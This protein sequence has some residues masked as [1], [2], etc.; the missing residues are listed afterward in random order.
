MP[1]ARFEVLVLPYATEA[2]ADIAFAVFRDRVLG[3][4]CWHAVRGGGDRGEL[5]LDAARRHA[6]A[7][8]GI[9]R[10]HAHVALDSRATVVIEAIAG[11]YE[12]ALH[13]FGVCV[14][15][16]GLCVC[17]GRELRWLS[18]RAA[19]GLL[20]SE[21]E[22]DALWELRHRIGRHPACR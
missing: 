22:R 7:Q 21:P 15:P 3:D 19:S 6:S 5:P 11:D 17:D 1:R 4:G 18:Y 13:A 10:G 8:A 14:D 20:A 2:F 16:A 12:I 9:D